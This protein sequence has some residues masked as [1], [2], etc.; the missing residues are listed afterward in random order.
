MEIEAITL[1]TG[2]WKDAVYHRDAVLRHLTATDE[3][4]LYEET[5]REFPACRA[6]ELLEC[7]VMRIGQY[8]PPDRETLCALTVGDR[9]TLLLNIRR[10]TFGNA[11]DAQ[12]TC[13][14]CHQDLD[15]S[16]RVTELLMLPY[17]NPEQ[18]HDD[19]EGLTP[20]RFRLPNGGDL[21]EAA[22]LAGVDS[23]RAAQLILRRCIGGAQAE[24]NAE[25]VGRLS[26]QMAE[27]DPQ[28]EL[29]LRPVCPDC[30]AQLSALLDVTSFLLSEIDRHARTLLQQVHQLAFRYHWSEAEI[31]AMPVRRRQTYLELIQQELDA[32]YSQ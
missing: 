31:L 22:P 29:V 11:L 21:E 12:L 27:L 25:T 3:L 18:W 30:G 2:L 13:P 32:H 28:A 23:E 10:L 4:F 19:Q 14:E 7:C 24:L 26:A 8:A 16:L 6:T 1:P 20:V 5:R 9:E 15:L 17:E